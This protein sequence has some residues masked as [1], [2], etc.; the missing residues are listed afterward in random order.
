MRQ[1]K[2]GLLMDREE[3]LMVY[4]EIAHLEDDEYDPNMNLADRVFANFMNESI[5][6]E[7]EESLNNFES[8]NLKKDNFTSNCNLSDTNSEDRNS[9]GSNFSDSP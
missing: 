2:Q 3:A 5:M 4:A 1:R 8:L 9:D 6:K 7:F